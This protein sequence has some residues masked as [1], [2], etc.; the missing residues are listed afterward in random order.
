MRRFRPPAVPLVTVDPY[1][2]IWSCSDTLHHDTTRHWTLT[3]HPLVGLIRIDDAIY[4]FLGSTNDGPAWHN[5]RQPSGMHQEEV[6]VEPTRTVCRFVDRGVELTVTFL[7][8][9]LVS[10]LD[11]MSRPFSYVH[12]GVRAIDGGKHAVRLYLEAS[13]RIAGVE[14]RRSGV[15]EEADVGSGWRTLRAGFWAQDVLGHR[16]DLTTIDWGY[17]HL[18]SGP[19]ATRRIGDAADIRRRF[20]TDG[21]LPGSAQPNGERGRSNS[22]PPPVLATA[23]DLGDLVAVGEN[24]PAVER[25]AVLG[26]DD[27]ASIDYF[28]TP[29]PAYCFRDGATFRSVAA[30]AITEWPQI[31]KRCET[32]DTTLLKRARAAAGDRFADLVALAYRQSIGA[33]KLIADEQGNPV[34]LSKE[35]TSNG[36]IGTVDVSYPSMPLYLLLNP[37]LVAAMMR[38]V[39]RFAESD[40]WGEPYAPHDVGTYPRATGQTYGVLLDSVDVSHQMPVEECGNMLIMAAAY[41]DR[42]GSGAFANA[43]WETITRWADYLVKNGLDPENQLCTDDFAG[44]LARNANLS[45]KAIVGIACYARL[46]EMTSKG[47]SARYM[48]IARDYAQTWMTMADDGDHYRL[49]FDGE[50]S[51]SLKYNLVWDRYF[52]F[53]LFPPEVAH[54]EVAWYLKQADTYGVPLDSRAAFTKTDW[55]VWAATLADERT[56]RAAIID[57]VW[58]FADETPDRTPFSDWYDTHDAREQSFHNR[59]VIGGI[60]MPLLIDSVESGSR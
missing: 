26:Y 1:F 2:S 51:W 12:F 7:T 15:W 29:R 17:V 42:A 25:L 6:R 28:G 22:N 18:M 20:A 33:H 10:D 58:K 8:P 48:T 21:D 37:D 45:V 55:L 43:H 41:C 44:H 57:L 11:L 34:F 23:W 36:S 38:P 54:R 31:R 13:S 53:D 4:R 46:C 50:G 24:G 35:C 14:P 47:D 49:T 56:Q 9:L 27:V 5:H 60:F 40:A 30:S 19:R 32:F 16:G 39:F 59:T 52:G 3:E